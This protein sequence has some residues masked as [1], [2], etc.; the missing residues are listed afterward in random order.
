MVPHYPHQRR[1]W[2][3]PA[4]PR[5]LPP[6]A[7]AWTGP[8]SLPTPPPLRL[9]WTR[10]L[11]RPPT[12]P[13]PYASWFVP[14]IKGTQAQGALG[15]ENASSR[16]CWSVRAALP[17]QVWTP[18]GHRALVEP[19]WSSSGRVQTSALQP[20]FSA[21]RSGR[22]CPCRGKP[23]PWPCMQYR[24]HRRAPRPLLAGSPPGAVGLRQGP[25]ADTLMGG[26]RRLQPGRFCWSG[27]RVSC[28]LKAAQT[29]YPGGCGVVLRPLPLFLGHRAQHAA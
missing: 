12:P 25:Q 28:S 13:P 19:P 18:G 4:T 15:A 23:R 5:L 26:P 7:G 20:L 27:G 22:L 9:Q 10:P 8:A 6:L 1:R 2:S 11:T 24:P 3:G 21:R 16:V 29:G 17:T 14:R